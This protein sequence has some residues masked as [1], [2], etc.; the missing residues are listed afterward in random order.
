MKKILLVTVVTAAGFLVAISALAKQTDPAENGPRVIRIDELQ[1]RRPAVPFD[2][3][4]HASIHGY[5]IKCTTCH[6]KSKGTDV[7]TTCSDCHKSRREGR[8]LSLKGA[9][10][11][12]C[13]GCHV[14]YNNKM[15]KQVAPHRCEDCHKKTKT[16]KK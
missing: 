8:R 4:K 16:V 11:K 10:H 1:Q 7:E 5:N 2:H 15:H 3:F 6:H 12:R 13:V 14:M 9:F